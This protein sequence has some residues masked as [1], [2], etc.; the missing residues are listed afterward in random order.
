MLIN[1]K[2]DFDKV[3]YQNAGMVEI[4]LNCRKLQE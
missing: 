2:H 3:S 1:I 4:S